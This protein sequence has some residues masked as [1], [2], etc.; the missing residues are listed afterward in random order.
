MKDIM[1]VSWGHCSKCT[2]CTEFQQ[3]RSDHPLYPTCGYCMCSAVLHDEKV[4]E[5]VVE[6]LLQTLSS[7]SINSKYQ[8]TK[9]K[10]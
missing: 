6:N 9:K 3:V 7:T 1:G 8:E 10:S 5:D 2:Q 4:E